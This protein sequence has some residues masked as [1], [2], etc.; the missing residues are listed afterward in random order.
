MSTN[1]EP[2]RSSPKPL[3]GAELE[4]WR[5]MLQVH[6]R[7]TQALDAQMQAE[8]GF[9]VSAYEVLMFLG[10]APGHR[11][12]MA[13]I[14][15]RVLL[16]RSGCTRLVDRLSKLGYVTRFATPDDGRGLYAELT[17][18]G[19]DKLAAA[20]GTHYAGV[21]QQFLDGLSAADQAALAAIWKRALGPRG[22]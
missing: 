21:R 3:K 14:A 10:D 22:A 12:R 6:A 2:A 1:A 7:V 5:G 20:R 16:T 13:E 8:H 4:A 18:A 19:L 9:S 17:P 15:D 11:L